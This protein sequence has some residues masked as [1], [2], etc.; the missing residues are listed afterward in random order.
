MTH[1]VHP[2]A[3]RL[4]IIRDW[5]SRWFDVDKYKEFLRGDVLI[6][7]YL[8]KR[9]KGFYVASIEFERSG[10]VLK[11][12]IKTSRPGMIIGRQGEGS[13]KLKV[14][15]VKF[16]KRNK[17]LSG[18]LKIEIEEIRFPESN[19]HVVAHM[20]VEALEKRLQFRR[21]LKQTIS[22]VMAN[23]DVLGARIALSGRLGGTEMGRREVIMQGMIPLQTFRADIDF[24]RERAV[25]PY[26]TIGIK[27]WIYKGEV[28]ADKVSKK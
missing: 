1:S 5:K 26:G 15:V 24:A 2:Y 8:Q 20:V 18:D 16:I 12:I 9:L 10:K 4:G 21:V 23:K 13:V 14:D 3:H 19:A 7:E 6:R 25:L 22:K 17:I 11:I 28:F 27:I